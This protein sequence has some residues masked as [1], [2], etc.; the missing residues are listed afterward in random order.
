MYERNDRCGRQI[1]FIEILCILAILGLFAFLDMPALISM[2][3]MLS[4]YEGCVI[5]HTILKFCLLTLEGLMCG[6]FKT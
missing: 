2:R 1:C 6:N 3:Y 4:L 5:K